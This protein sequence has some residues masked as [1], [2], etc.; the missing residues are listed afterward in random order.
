[1]T[2]EKYY[3]KFCF[4]STHLYLPI[5]YNIIYTLYALLYVYILFKQTTNNRAD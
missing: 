2:R 4:I 3:V 5:V 1:M